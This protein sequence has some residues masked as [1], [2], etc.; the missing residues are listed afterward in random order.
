MKKQ[1][2]CLHFHIFKNAGSTVDW[3]LRRT[4][5]S[6]F[7]TTD[8]PGPGDRLGPDAVLRFMENHPKISALSS[9]Q[10][11][12]PLPE[13]DRHAYYPILF[14]RHPVDRALSIYRFERR[15]GGVTPGSRKAEESTLPEYVRWR[16]DQGSVS[17]LA[18]FQTSVLSYTAT[19]PPARPLTEADLAL[20]AS[21]LRAC[22]VPGVVEKLDESLVCAEEALRPLL[23]RVDLAYVPQNVSGGRAAA[24]SARLER[25][26]ADLGAAL[27]DELTARNACDFRLHDLATAEL[28]TRTASIPDFESKLAH[29]RKRCAKLSP[30]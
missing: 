3:A 24:L 4:L 27:A 16:L 11:R 6:K 28:A 10:F 2:V 14:I 1:P 17:V 7:A 22:L 8:G 15:Q 23:G 25:G 21:N 29:F 20:A 5:R 9:H 18:D 26:R 13:S 12:F 19:D 30:K